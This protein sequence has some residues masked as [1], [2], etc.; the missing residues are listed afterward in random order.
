MENKS[1][2]KV[3]EFFCEPLNFGGQEAFIIN[4][5]QKFINKKVSYTFFTPFECKNDR[6]KKMV[7]NNEDNIMYLDYNFETKLRK[8]N[9]IKGAKKIFKDNMYDVVHIHSGSIF[10]LYF[11]AKLAKKGGVQKVIIHSHSTGDNTFKYR[12]IKKITDNKMKK[13]VDVFLACSEK[14]AIWKFPKEIISFGKY[15]IIKNGVDLQSFK[16]NNDT[17]QKIRSEYGIDDKNVIINIGRFSKEK[18]QDFLV[19]VFKKIK[20]INPNAY[21]IL[22]GGSGPLKKDIESKI[23][24]Y[25]LKKDVLI[26]E[27][28]SNV[29]D[30]LQAADVFALPSLY[31]GFPVVAVEAQTSGLPIICSDTITKEVML[32]S[33]CY[34][35][36]LDEEIDNWAQ[37]INEQFNGIRN[38]YEEE[39]KNKGFDIVDTARILENIYLTG[40]KNNEENNK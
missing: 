9:I 4:V 29:P 37:K 31:E 3:L 27:N 23:E 7:K 34:F 38:N 21:M 36:S 5:Y 26:L 17:R 20:E 32:T 8:L 28:I 12:I 18:N 15:E 19:E 2:V 6:L 1:N 30:F 16:F 33:T 10:S 14:A 40:D 22:I 25:N 24:E 35:L 11:V 13:Y 39:I